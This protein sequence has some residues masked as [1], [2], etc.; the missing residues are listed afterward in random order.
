ML[1]EGF[2]P[3]GWWCGED[4]GPIGRAWRPGQKKE[5]TQERR[6][7]RLGWRDYVPNAYRGSL[8]APLATQAIE[9]L[10]KVQTAFLE[11]PNIMGASE[12]PIQMAQDMKQGYQR[13]IGDK[14][15]DVLKTPTTEGEKQIA[16]GLRNK[17]G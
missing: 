15:Y 2:Q 4:E 3:Y 13:A 7:L 17:S 9:D 8:T 11:H 6:S 12:I 16:R 5:V 10:G 1:K 14:G